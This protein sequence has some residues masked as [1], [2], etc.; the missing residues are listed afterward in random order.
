MRTPLPPGFGHIRAPG[1]GMGAK[2]VYCNE[3]CQPAYLDCEELQGRRPQEHSAVDGAVDWLKCHHDVVLAGSVV[4]IAG[5]AFIVAFP[6]G[7]LI[8][9]VPLTAFSS[10]EA[11]CEPRFAREGGCGS[12]GSGLSRSNTHAAYQRMRLKPVWPEWRFAYFSHA[13]FSGLSF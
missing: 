4:T 8:A 13:V 11:V 9:L 10:S 2:E 1:R 5:V 6:P 7:A 3:Q 12:R